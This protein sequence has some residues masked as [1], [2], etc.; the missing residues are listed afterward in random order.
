MPIRIRLIVLTFIKLKKNMKKI[1]SFTISAVLASV[2]LLTLYSYFISNDN[3][4]QPFI[5]ALTCVS[6]GIIY[7]YKRKGIEI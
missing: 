4:L 5:L 3:R 7:Y 6:M 1:I 2:P